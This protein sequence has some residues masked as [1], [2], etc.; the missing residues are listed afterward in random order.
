MGT[1]QGEAA[2]SGR[3]ARCGWPYKAELE[4]LRALARD[5]PDH[6]GDAW[7]VLVTKIFKVYDELRRRY[8]NRELSPEDMHRAAADL[9]ALAD[10]PGAVRL[11]PAPAVDGAR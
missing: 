1:A 3:A 5:Y 10:R 9:V 4:V 7:V 11:R 2:V 6:R 8:R